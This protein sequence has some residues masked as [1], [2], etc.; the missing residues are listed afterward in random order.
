MSGYD[1]ESTKPLLDPRPNIPAQPMR[2][3]RILLGP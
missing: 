3:R 1:S 2:R